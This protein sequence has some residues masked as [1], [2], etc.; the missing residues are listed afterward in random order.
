[1]SVENLFPICPGPRLNDPPPA[2]FK[3]EKQVDFLLGQKFGR[4]LRAKFKHYCNAGNH[5]SISTSQNTTC[6]PSTTFLRALTTDR[7][8]DET[9]WN[10]LADVPFFQKPREEANG[11]SVVNLFD[12]LCWS[13]LS[14]LRLNDP[15]SPSHIYVWIKV[16]FL[17]GRKFRAKFKLYQRWK[18]LL[19]S[20][21]Q[22][23]L[24]NHQ[25]YNV[26]AHPTYSGEKPI[27]NGEPA[28]GRGTCR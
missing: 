7:Y 22:N 8:S 11:I 14:G 9:T 10:Q 25:L 4:E 2:T 12:I 27:E 6:K 28:D 3:D 24:A 17:L 13:G 19:D 21:S 26:P 18:S 15:H 5:S 20:T 16:D 1:M 23:K